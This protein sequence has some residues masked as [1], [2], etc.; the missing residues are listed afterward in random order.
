MNLKEEINERWKSA[1][2]ARDNNLKSLF[3]LIKAKVLMEEKSGKYQLPL[4][5]NI[6]QNIIIR[7]VKE[8]KET[9]S[10]HKEDS[11]EY[12]DLEFKINVL[13]EYLPKQLTEEEVKSIIK[14]I[15]SNSGETNLGKII[16][17][18][19]KEIGNNYDKSKIAGLVR[20]VMN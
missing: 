1:F 11:I 7:E 18:S 17:L 3:E 16:G 12:Q 9:Q 8:M 20:E 5:D 13:N 2:K 19:V 4:E 6:I 15:I 14:D 10:Y